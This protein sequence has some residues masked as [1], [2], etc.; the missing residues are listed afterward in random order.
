M[1]KFVPRFDYITHF[2]GLSPISYTTVVV[3]ITASTNAEEA[4]ASIFSIKKCIK[5]ACTNHFKYYIVLKF[6]LIDIERVY[7]TRIIF[8]KKAHEN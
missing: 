5:N 6:T 2:L 4:M 1:H 8:L 7:Y 3:F